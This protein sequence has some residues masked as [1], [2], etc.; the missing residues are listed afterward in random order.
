M[1]QTVVAVTADLPAGAKRVVSVTLS[2]AEETFHVFTDKVVKQGVL[3]IEVIFVNNECELA[4]FTTTA[5]FVATVEIP[6]ARQGTDV[7]I[8][9]R[10]LRIEND[11]TKVGEVLTG[12][13]VIIEFVKVS[14]FVQRFLTTCEGLTIPRLT[15]TTP[16]TT[17]VVSSVS[18][19][20][21]HRL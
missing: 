8:Q 4:T 1:A 15:T 18:R 10:N 14:Q 19:H 3:V 12:K 6:G 21:E 5:P 20:E 9:F 13:V 17:V 16:T 7:D 11:L 2:T